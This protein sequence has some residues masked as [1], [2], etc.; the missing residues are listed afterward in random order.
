MKEW[1]STI[2]WFALAGGVVYGASVY[3]D[4][5]RK[6]RAAEC[7]ASEECTK[8]RAELNAARQ[9]SATSEL[10]RSSS[11]QIYFRGVACKSDCDELRNG[12]QF[13]EKVGLTNTDGCES[14]NEAFENGCL[15]YYDELIESQYDGEDND[16]RN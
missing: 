1:I 5:K 13:A 16:P 9:S 3:T 2:A 12:F 7:A 10:V 6:V 11:G 14:P 8:Q 15:A 4:Q